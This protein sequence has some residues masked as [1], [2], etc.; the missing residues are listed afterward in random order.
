[1]TTAWYCCEDCT[2]CPYRGQYCQA[3]DPDQP[4][5]LKLRKTFWEK[6]AGSQKNIETERRDHLRLCRSIQVEGAFGLLKNDFGFRRF[7]TRGKQNVRTELFFLA[8]AFNLKKLYMKREKG[9]LRTQLSVV[10]IA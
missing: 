6:R 7:L 8:L 10:M 3:K 2:D 5:E 9:R 1:M 4:K